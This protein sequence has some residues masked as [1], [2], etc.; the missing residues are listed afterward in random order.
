VGEVHADSPRRWTPKK[1]T[2]GDGSP[3]KRYRWWQPFTRTL[4][5][6]RLRDA[7]GSVH[8]WSMDVRL[9]GDD[10]GVVRA[11]LYR[12]GFEHSVS[13]LPAAFPVP[14]GEIE[15]VAS[16]YGLKRCHF[17]GHDGPVRQLSPD[18]SSAEGWRA[19]LHRRSPGASRALGGVSIAILVVALVLGVPQIVEQVSHIPWVADNVGTFVSPIRLPAWFNISLLIATLLASTERA[20][21]LRYNWLLDG[22]FFDGEE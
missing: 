18:P 5:F 1:V 8:T 6:A 14:G 4:F 12:D 16:G 17:V 9:G 10:N 22:G 3:L 2:P 15:V 19:R 13:K 11:K 21:R 20:L 7:D